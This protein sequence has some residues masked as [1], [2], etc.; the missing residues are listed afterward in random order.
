MVLVH[1]SSGSTS[2]SCYASAVL[3]FFGS[4]FAFGSGYASSS[5]PASGFG[6]YL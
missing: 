3:I 2:S 4:G 5:G 6:S 1:Y